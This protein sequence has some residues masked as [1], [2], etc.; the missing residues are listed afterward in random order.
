MD[1]EVFNLV[2]RPTIIGLL[3]V[4]DIQLYFIFVSREIITEIEDDVDNLN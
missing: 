4:H 3:A 2:K 1:F